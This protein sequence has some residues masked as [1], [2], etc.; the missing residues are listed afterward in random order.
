MSTPLVRW[1]MV[2]FFLIGCSND[3]GTATGATASTARWYVDLDAPVGGDGTSWSR[4]SRDLATV[5]AKVSPSDEV[6]VASGTHRPGH[7]GATR[8]SAFVL[9]ESLRLYGG[10]AGGESTL[11]ARDPAAHPT[12]LDGDL[13]GD[14]APNFEN[15]AD[16]AYH[17]VVATDAHHA[18]IDGFT[19]RG[20]Y[21]D[22]LGLGP[23]PE[24]RDQGSGINIYHGPITVRNCT[25]TENWAS[26]HGTVNDHSTGSIF[27]SCAFVANTSAQ[28]GAGLYLHHEA[29]TLAFDCSF[30]GNEA[31]TDGAGCYV[32]ARQGARIEQCHFEGNQ[33]ER[34]GGIYAAPESAPVVVDCTFVANMGRT[35]GGGSYNDES[36]SEFQSCEFVSNSA[37][38]GIEGGSA[39][40]GGS[41]GGGIWTNGGAM[42]AM[43][44]VFRRNRASFGGGFYAIHDAEALVT[45][46]Y[47]ENNHAEEAGGMYTLN[48]P[49]VLLDSTFVRNVAE[50]GAFSV[51]GGMSNYFSDGY[52]EGCSFHGNRAELGGGGLYAEG[53]DP[54][55]R[56]CR[57][58][59]NT[60]EGLEAFGGAFFSGYFTRGLVEDC[61]F[62]GNDAKFGGGTFDIAFSETRYANCTYSRNTAASGSNGYVGNLSTPRHANCILEGGTL[63]RFGGLDADFEYGLSERLAFGA[64]N[65]AGV[66]TFVRP[67][68]S[69]PDEIWGTDDDD[70]GD[71]RLSAGSLGI[72]A[73]S[74]AAHTRGLVL[75]LGLDPRFIDDPAV[76]DVGV[77]EGPI[78]DM[79]AFERQP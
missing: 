42:C 26:H 20:G 9:V 45:G 35:G 78:V 13:A 40:S 30:R 46:C 62:V 70:G 74:N 65:V 69:G 29:A 59:G 68:S 17:V 25:L 73:G 23:T 12:I 57:F 53:E 66:P 5:L 33:A 75:D 28:F 39:G 15:R 19:I 6:W 60:T 64:G 52:I 55:V 44:C 18:V 71:L 32:R 31:G 4:A 61:S 24:S 43:D 50:N 38:L 36:F 14:D 63:Q 77:G 2:G 67:P 21:A 76:S 48:S 54:I 47:F 79:G 41:G 3:T 1:A 72:D 51:G 8:D 11:A 49:V 56:R 58:V 27:E 16:N 22:G 10:F 7:A 34:G 37:G